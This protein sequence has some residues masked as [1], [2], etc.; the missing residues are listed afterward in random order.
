[1]FNYMSEFK[2]YVSCYVV[3]VTTLTPLQTAAA[4]ESVAPRRGNAMAWDS[5]VLGVLQRY[6]MTLLMRSLTENL[7]EMELAVLSI[8]WF[9]WVHP[10]HPGCLLVALLPVVN[11]WGKAACGQ[12]V[13]SKSHCYISSR[14]TCKETGPVCCSM[15]LATHGSPGQNFHVKPQIFW[16]KMMPFCVV[17]IVHSPF[18]RFLPVGVATTYENVFADSYLLATWQVLPL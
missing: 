3:Y 1:M 2:L 15:Q 16:L 12:C 17:V 18:Y 13:P 8:L 5:W 11:S 14:A 7:W 6:Q 10:L 4:P 9:D